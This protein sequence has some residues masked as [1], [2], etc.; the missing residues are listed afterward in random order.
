VAPL[1]S[2]HP[3]PLLQTCPAHG[4]PAPST[5][6]LY[7]PAVLP[8]R[9]LAPFFVISVF[10]VYLSVLFFLFFLFFSSPSSPSLSLPSPP[11]VFFSSSTSLTPPTLFL[12]SPRSLCWPCLVTYFL[13]LDHS[14][15]MAVLSLIPTI[16]TFPSSNPWNNHI[17]TLCTTQGKMWTFYGFSTAKQLSYGALLPSFLA[18][19]DNGV[20]EKV[21]KRHLPY[22]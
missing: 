6:F 15:A 14:R 9:S 22:T 19:G 1:S 21:R 11:L 8:R 17:L 20:H 3:T 4:F 18:P 5:S 7:H 10:C 2:S 16:K 12:S 13:S